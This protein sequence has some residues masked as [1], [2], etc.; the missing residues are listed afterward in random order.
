MKLLSRV[1]NRIVE[2]VFY[3][4]P[5]FIRSKMSNFLYNKKGYNWAK[6]C[7]LDYKS[8]G[9]PPKRGKASI[10]NYDFNDVIPIFESETIKNLLDKNALFVQVGG[11]SGKDVAH[12]ANKFK[13]NKF[14]YTDIAHGAVRYASEKYGHNTNIT[15][16]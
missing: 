8:V 6:S 7:D 11:S 12:F 3:L 5:H 13:K 16:K 14:I 2:E 4:S 9:Y 10:Y 15:F 1:L